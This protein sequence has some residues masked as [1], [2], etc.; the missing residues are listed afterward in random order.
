MTYGQVLLALADPTRRSL[1]ER[2]RHRPCTVGELADFAQIRQPSVSQHLRVLRQ[3]RL[4][5]DRRDGTRRYY[6]ASR[7]G[8]AELRRYVESLWDDVL[9]AYAAD[10]P[11][12]PA[13]RGRAK[14]RGKR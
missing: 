9:T 13:R 8:L 5:S 11:Q 14:P 7:Q 3:A 12:P 1:L 6:R 10:D 2:M 4:V